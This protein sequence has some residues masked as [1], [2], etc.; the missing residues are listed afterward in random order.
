MYTKFLLT[1]ITV[2][3]FMA[4]A[5]CK[6]AEPQTIEPFAGLS[7]PSFGFVKQPV[8]SNGE[9]S[10]DVWPYNNTQHPVSSTEVVLPAMNSAPAGNNSGVYSVVANAADKLAESSGV[11]EQFGSTNGLNNPGCTQEGYTGPNNFYTVPGTFQSELSP[12]FMNQDFGANI[13]YN[14]P[15][16]EHLAAE[17][18]N[19]LS[20]ANSV[21]NFEQ[22]EQENY[23]NV[24]TKFAQ[25]HEPVPLPRTMDGPQRE[26]YDAN[27]ANAPNPGA[28]TPQFKIYDRLITTTSVHGRNGQTNPAD[29]I[30][31]DLAILPTTQSCGWFQSRF[32]SPA[33][34]KTGALDVLAG[35]NQTSGALAAIKSQYTSAS[36]AAGGNIRTDD[37]MAPL[38]NT[39]KAINDMTHKMDPSTRGRSVSGV[40]A[41]Y[42]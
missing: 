25:V 5:Y 38:Q 4:V 42:S 6:F 17:P 1:I 20:L 23:E 3:S 31:G 26:D 16:Q 21:E 2:L 9:V 13:T 27:D 22:Q 12:R 40:Y 30:R 7:Y 34:L 36:T 33:N 24:E 39:V 18:D 14:F 19:P 10:V 11:T 32:A 28:A 8:L 37:D 29:P 35:A 15:A 41:A